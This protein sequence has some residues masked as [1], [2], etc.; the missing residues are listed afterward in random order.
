MGNTANFSLFARLEREMHEF[1]N[2][3]KSQSLF[4]ERII[5]SLSN[6][7]SQ[8]ISEI[9][10]KKIQKINGFDLS[11]YL[12]KIFKVYNI[13]INVPILKNWNF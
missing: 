13:L 9:F 12:L 5:I 8:L 7:I 3:D 4:L 2:T 1:M 10:L 6:S 11:L